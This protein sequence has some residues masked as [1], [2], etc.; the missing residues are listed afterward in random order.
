MTIDAAQI[1]QILLDF[2][3]ALE[4]LTVAVAIIIFVSSTD[5]F[6]IDA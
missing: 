3:G 2:R 1:T 6:F 5:D 4:W